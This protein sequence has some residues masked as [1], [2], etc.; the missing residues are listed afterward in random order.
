MN[1]DLLPQI[2]DIKAAERRLV[3]C[4]GD[5]AVGSSR[6]NAIVG[7]RLLVKAECLQR[8]GSFKFRG[9]F[10]KIAQIPE[11][12]ARWVSLRFPQVIMPRVWARS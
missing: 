12:D 8:T 4:K 2:S 10:N 3:G 5:P 7:A 9:A 1:T 6:L 11:R